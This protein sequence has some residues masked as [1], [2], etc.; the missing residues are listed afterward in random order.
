MPIK[1]VGLTDRKI[2]LMLGAVLI[3]LSLT[4]FLTNQVLEGLV[5]LGVSLIPIATSITGTC[6]FYCATK[7]S[8]NH[9]TNDNITL[10]SQR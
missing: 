10:T 7:R 9:S 1:N 2:R 8:T 5:L 6:P 4:F 3:L